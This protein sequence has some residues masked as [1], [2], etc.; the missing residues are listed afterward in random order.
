MKDFTLDEPRVQCHSPYVHSVQIHSLYNHSPPPKDIMNRSL[1]DDASQEKLSAPIQSQ[2]VDSPPLVDVWPVTDDTLQDMLGVQMNYSQFVNHS[3]KDDASQEKLSAR[4]QS[5][6]VDCPP[7]V[8]IGPVT[9]DTLQDKLGV[10]VNYSHISPV[11]A[12]SA[13][14]NPPPLADS[15]FVGRRKPCYGWIWNDDDDE[16]F[17][18]LTPAT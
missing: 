3:L 13:S 17:V 8:D 16:D 11:V 18:Y 1:K 9:D 7:L 4:I 2:F 12:V 14:M 6:F 10:Q 5:Q 15:C